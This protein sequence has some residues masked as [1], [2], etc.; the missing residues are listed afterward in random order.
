MNEEK[1]EQAKAPKPVNNYDG[2]LLKESG[3]I[4]RAIEDG[5]NMTERARKTG[6][7]INA[8]PKLKVLVPL[9]GGEQFGVY[10]SV[11]I[12]GYRWRVP[13]GVEVEVPAE[14]ARAIHNKQLVEQMAGA[15][16]LLANN[17]EAQQASCFNQK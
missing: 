6:E 7:I 8:Q 17:P 9:M 15:D 4:G 5:V 16:M 11:I 12:N 1:K 14:V 10:H 13:K 3:M 2:G